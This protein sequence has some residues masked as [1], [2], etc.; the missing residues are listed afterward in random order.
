MRSL[1]IVDYYTDLLVLFLG[2]FTGFYTN[3][4][5]DL[6]IATSTFEDHLNFLSEVGTINIK[7]LNFF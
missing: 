6:L 7:N 4:W 5:A 1:C 3:F 2:V